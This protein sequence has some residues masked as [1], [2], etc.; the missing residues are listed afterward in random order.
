MFATL[1][2]EGLSLQKKTQ[3]MAEEKISEVTAR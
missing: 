1:V 2:K 3:G